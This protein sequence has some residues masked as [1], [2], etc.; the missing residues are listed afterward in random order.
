MEALSKIGLPD[1]FMRPQGY[2]VVFFYVASATEGVPCDLKLALTQP[3]LFPIIP[4]KIV[5]IKDGKTEGTDRCARSTR[6]QE[7]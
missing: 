7:K 4:I 2:P 5:C 3:H 6:I 1:L